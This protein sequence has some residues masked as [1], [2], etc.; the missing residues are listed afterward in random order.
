VAIG[1][2]ARQQFGGDDAG[3]A[4]AKIET[5]SFGALSA[6]AVQILAAAATAACSTDPAKLTEAINNIENLEVTTGT[7]TYKG[8]NGVPDKDVSILTVEGGAPAFVEALRPAN[9][10]D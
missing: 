9:V 1:R 4:G 8:R 5:I 10:P 6:D 3:A 7:V 2:G